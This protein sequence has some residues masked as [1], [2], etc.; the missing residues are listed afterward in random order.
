MSLDPLKFYLDPRV[1]RSSYWYSG[2][3]DN[4]VLGTAVP[5]DFIEYLR[6]FEAIFEKA[7][8]RESAAQM[9]LFDE[10]EPV[11]QV[12]SLGLFT[13]QPFPSIGH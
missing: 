6:E 5:T 10:K 11:S 4:A 3:I 9:G 7:S 1:Q 13:Y 12:S 8:S 2:V